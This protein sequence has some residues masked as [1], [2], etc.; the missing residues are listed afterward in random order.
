[1]PVEKGDIDTGYMVSMLNL[2]TS[3]NCIVYLLNIAFDA[4][5]FL[6]LL[7]LFLISVWRQLDIETK[8]LNW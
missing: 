2:N 3:I 1:M 4:S 7:L 8:Y 5:N 6:F